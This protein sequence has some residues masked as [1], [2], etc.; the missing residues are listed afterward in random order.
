MTKTVWDALVVGAGPSGSTAAFFLA[1][2]GFTVLIEE[3]PRVGEP[4]HCTGIVGEEIFKEFDLPAALA[5]RELRPFMVRS[6][7]GAVLELPSFL[8]VFL[9]DR[10]E[11]DRYLS[12]SAADAGAVL[13]LNAKARAVE[14]REDLVTV[15]GEREGEKFEL[16]CRICILATGAGSS[17]SARAVG[18]P[19]AY[20][21][22]V[23]QAV[24]MPS[25]RGV[26]LYVGRAVA[27]GSFAY[28]V[29]DCGSGARIGL[30][31]RRDGCETWR[32][33]EAMPAIRERVEEPLGSPMFR[34]LPLGAALRSVKGNVLLVGD[35]AGQAKS[36]TGG[37]IYF[38]LVGARLLAETVKDAY[39][40]GSFCAADLAD[41]DRRWK[42]RLGRE[43]GIGVFVRRVFS[44]VRDESLEELV[45]ILNSPEAR[46]VTLREGRWDSHRG[47]VLG[48]MRLA[49]FRSLLINILKDGL[50][51]GCTQ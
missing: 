51:M 11:L 28:A 14:Q 17:L 48:L 25:L 2:A 13:Q 39:K 50:A 24:R 45:R 35:A 21:E 15:K 26:E 47:L 29:E 12:K 4:V 20:M 32:R 49:P 3:H 5:L 18:G 30:M 37:G 7:G 22:S 19:R 8:K 44:T 16:K 43:I 23:Q 38:G 41:Y 10:A 36:T 46:A 42:H 40:G 1:R 9:T 33:F 6:P 31:V 34:R 27:P